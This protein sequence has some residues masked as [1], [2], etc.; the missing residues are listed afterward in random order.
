MGAHVLRRL[1]FYPFLV[2][3]LLVFPAWLPWMIACWLV[4]AAVRNRREKPIWPPLAMCVAILVI[5]RVDW[6]PA[7][8]VL[9]LLMLAC[10]GLDVLSRKKPALKT[11]S[12]V[13]AALLIPAWFAMAWTWTASIHTSRHPALLADPPIVCMGDSLSSA[14]YPRILEK[15]LRVPVVDLAQGGYTTSDAL[16]QIGEMMALKPQMVVIELGGHDSMRGRDR[17]EARANLQKLIVACRVVG[18]E[19]VL[20]EIP[21][22]FVSDPYG[23]LDRELARRHDLE[24]VHDGA[25]RQLVLFSPFTPL[26]RWTG[27]MLSYD[28][29]HPNDAGNAF[30]ADRVEAALERVY[31]TS[32][33]R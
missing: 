8:V 29:L 25:I 20:F 10:I 21:L 1:A 2:A 15:R 24:L 5:K 23:G 7:F 32:L 26:G 22:G 18:A 4:L 17:V 6:P 19:T 14:G 12:L 13:A 27:R 16:K 33:R 3:S 31:G 11:V 30:L 28:G 9:L